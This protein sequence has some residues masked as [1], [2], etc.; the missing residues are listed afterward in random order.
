MTTEYGKPIQVESC[1]PLL[2][3]PVAP[4]DA[5]RAAGRASELYTRGDMRLYWVNCGDLD[6]LRFAR[7]TPDH[8]E[9]RIT[10]PQISESAAVA[11]SPYYRQESSSGFE[12][13]FNDGWLAACRHF[14][15][16]HE[17]TDVDRFMAANPTSDRDTA[18]LAIAFVKD[19]A[20]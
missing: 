17:D 8:S 14:N 4:T 2:L 1:G 5:Q 11:L 16:V 13:Y 6:V 15:I 20:A 3:L 18:K 7:P 19:Q 9:D 12:Q 10:M